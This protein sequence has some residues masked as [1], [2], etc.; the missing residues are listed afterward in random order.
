[1]EEN[2]TIEYYVWEAVREALQYESTKTPSGESITEKY[3]RKI[4]RELQSREAKEESKSKFIE[5]PEDLRKKYD[6]VAF[7]ILD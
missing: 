4:M 7:L 2:R 1:M 5:L 6:V 3:Y